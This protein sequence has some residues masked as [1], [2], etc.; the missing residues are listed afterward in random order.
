MPEI[1]IRPAS[2]EDVPLILSFVKELAGS[3]R[4]ST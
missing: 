1:G 2:E 3:E 4:I